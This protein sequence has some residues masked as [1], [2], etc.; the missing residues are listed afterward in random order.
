MGQTARLQAIEKAEEL[1]ELPCEYA[2][3]KSRLRET[4]R[5]TSLLSSTGTLRKEGVGERHCRL[6]VTQ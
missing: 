2:I 6:K 4:Y 5:F 1:A 3:K